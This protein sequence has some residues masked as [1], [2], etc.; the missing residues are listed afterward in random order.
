SCSANALRSISSSYSRGQR[1]ADL[2]LETRAVV[3]GEAGRQD[4]VDA[5]ETADLSECLLR[6]R[7]IH[8]HDRAR[9]SAR[10]PGGAQ[11]GGDAER[12]LFTIGD[13]PQ[14]A[15]GT[16][17]VSFCKYGRD[18]NGI[19]LEDGKDV[20]PFA[21]VLRRVNLLGSRSGRLPFFPF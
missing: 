12:A 8:E 21:R 6:D 11:H 17:R 13:K 19:L 15:A 4:D 7:E 10:R 5:V 20:A 16:K 2:L 1:G 9:C 18:E 3:S 14:R